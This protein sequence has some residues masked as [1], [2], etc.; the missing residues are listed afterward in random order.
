MA[1]SKALLVGI[2]KYPKRP[3]PGALNDVAEWGVLIRDKFAFAS[4]DINTITDAAATKTEIKKHFE[5]LLA[6][7]TGTGDRLLFYISSHG[8]IT[9]NQQGKPI[10]G[11]VAYA[12]GTPTAADVIVYSELA[13]WIKNGLKAKDKLTLMLDCCYAPAEAV[14]FDADVADRVKF[15]PIVEPGVREVAQL[16]ESS[17]EDFET[18]EAAIVGLVERMPPLILRATDDDSPAYEYTAADGKPYGL[19]SN[20]LAATVRTN[21]TW[22]HNQAMKQADYDVHLV[23]MD[24][25]PTMDGPR[26]GDPFLS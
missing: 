15:Y 20:K 14:V 7:G 10:P 18:L 9:L 16:F 19:F 21:P 17:V 13:A 11:M 5:K 25:E 1:N 8:T 26:K 22:T 2:S 24:Q 3:L 6:D 4:A 23:H 12:S